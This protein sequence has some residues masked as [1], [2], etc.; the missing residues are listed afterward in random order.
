MAAPPSRGK[1][2]LKLAGMTA[3]V[4]GNLAKT[5]V[6]ALFQSDEDAA[7]SREEANRESGNRIAKTL[8][9]LKGAVMKV[10]QMASIAHDVLPKELS[11]ALGQ[12]QR[13]APPM[14]FQLIAEQIE[15]ELG[16][17]PELLFKR[18]EQ[19]PFAAASI[20]Q[21]HRATTDDG[22]EVV[23]KVQYPGVE[24][25]VDS[26]LGQLK[27]ALLASG[28]VDIPRDALNASFKEIRER[29]HEELDYCN[30]ADNVRLFGDFH[31][32]HDFMIVPEVV[33]ER[34]S[35]RVLT[36]TYEPGDHLTELKDKGYTQA[37]RDA[38][39]RNLFRMMCAQVFELGIMHADPNPGN[40]AFRRDG[41]I[42]LYD[43][44]CAKRLRADII[45]AYKDMI[46]QGIAENWDAV[47]EALLR[48][49]LRR[50]GG[51][52]PDNEFYKRWRDTFAD[53]FLDVAIYDYGRST[54]HDEVVKLIPASVKRLASF[55]AATELI[56]LD[57]TVIGHYGNTRILEARV[58][59]WAL[60]KSYLDAFSGEF[61]ARPA[62]AA[63]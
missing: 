30:E 31:R 8:G 11:E 14:E 9:E 53:P 59:T 22:R 7:S 57:R 3:S 29:L 58:P 10:G 37:E 61:P 41:K 28:I 62:E 51:P 43:F 32:R 42:V 38:I 26:D 20:G 1:R 5:R 44:G 60:L 19:Q 21:V 4:A 16:A 54:L 2:F 55:Q 33:G 48:L 50:P 6:K 39:G 52:R 27:L 46:E 15:R 18:F 24:N 40:F 47:D 17:A 25:A 36:L 35:K 34:S 23:V 49:G 56:F 12:L 13:E 45:A 63:T